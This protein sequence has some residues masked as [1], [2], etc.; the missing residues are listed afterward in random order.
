MTLLRIE[1]I[2]EKH[3]LKESHFV[4]AFQHPEALL[5]ALQRIRSDSVCCFQIRSW[6]LFCEHPVSHGDGAAQQAEYEIPPPSA[7]N[8]HKPVGK[9]DT[10]TG[11]SYL[12]HL[13]PELWK[14]LESYL[15]KYQILITCD[16]F[17]CT[18]DHTC[19]LLYLRF[20]SG[21]R[22]L[23]LQRPEWASGGPL[24]DALLPRLLP[25]H[26]LEE[27]AHISYW[28]DK[29]YGLTAQNRRPVE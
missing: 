11:G 29:L 26:R 20:C 9:A 17:W 7:C 27:Y 10:V 5:P 14:I 13:P 18:T 12:S 4:G 3:S 16:H 23:V 24:V 2:L 19:I 21:L 6:S 1:A 25:V 22:R 8:M 28:D 15:N